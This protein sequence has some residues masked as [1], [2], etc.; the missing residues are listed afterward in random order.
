MTRLP[1]G[2]VKNVISFPIKT[3]N[4]ST[5]LGLLSN[6]SMFFFPQPSYSNSLSIFF[7]DLL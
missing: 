3:R 6:S 7:P 2:I 1:T 4:V 5:S